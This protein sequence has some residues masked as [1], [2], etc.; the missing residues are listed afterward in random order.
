MTLLYS[1]EGSPE[2]SEIFFSSI[3]FCIQCHSH[4]LCTSF[5]HRCGHLTFHIVLPFSFLHY[6][7]IEAAIR[8]TYH[9]NICNCSVSENI[10]AS[11][12]AAFMKCLQNVHLLKLSSSYMQ[13]PPYQ[14]ASKTTKTSLQKR[15]TRRLTIQSL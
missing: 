9:K 15:T 7:Y 5:L 10:Q 8:A 14:K 11:E 13:T 3:I 4:S 12:S 6:P 2:T 1:Y